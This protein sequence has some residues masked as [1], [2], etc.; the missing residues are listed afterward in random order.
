M[1]TLSFAE[2]LVKVKPEQANVEEKLIKNTGDA[3]YGD[4]L[5]GSA[6]EVNSLPGVTDATFSSPGA[7]PN[8]GSIQRKKAG[9]SRRFLALLIDYLVLEVFIFFATY[10]LKEKLISA[11]L[12][13][14]IWFDQFEMEKLLGL[15]A[16]YL[17]YCLVGMVF[18]GFYFTFFHGISG[19]TVG[20][21]LLK[22]KVVKIDGSSLDFYDAFIRWIGFM[23]GFFVCGLGL[24]WALFNKDGRGW[25]DKIA[26]TIVIKGEEV[27]STNQ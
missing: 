18:W 14:S 8:G 12:D 25:H 23:F 22:I 6:E 9:F 24:L 11:E 3:V 19:K 17:F 20:K 13:Y 10:P 1:A 2:G 15:L 27:E 26:G 16:F 5:E 7:L 4:D 21:S